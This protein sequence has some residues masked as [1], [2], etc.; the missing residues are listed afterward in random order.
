[1]SVPGVS[2]TVTG[3]DSEGVLEQA[4]HLGIDFKPM[5]DEERRALLA[6]TAKAARKG[7]WEKFKTTQ[8]FD[9]T[10]QHRQWLTTANL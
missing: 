5:P 3:C 6:R 10:E 2:L 7:K 4:L 1:M 8:T 9:G